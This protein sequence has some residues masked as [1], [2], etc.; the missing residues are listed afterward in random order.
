MIISEN[1]EVIILL[2]RLE[3]GRVIDSSTGE[4]MIEEVVY[5]KANEGVKT[6]SMPKQSKFEQER[7]IAWKAKD[8]FVKL[9]VDNLREVISELTSSETFAVMSVISYID[10]YSNMLK[11]YDGLPLNT[12]D[13]A[14]LTGFSEK[15]TIGLMD[16]LV[17]KKIF[18]RNRVG[19][20]Y[21]YFANPFIFTKGNRINA[22]LYAMFK[23]YKSKKT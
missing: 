13:I 19:R 6:Y 20:S 3:D 10:Y 16:S 18:A 12:A 15:H 17:T 4:L 22:T 9:Y 21:Q 14:T 2:K 1:S 8:K 11:G 5:R 7:T 23:N